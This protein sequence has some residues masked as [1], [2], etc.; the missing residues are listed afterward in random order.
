MGAHMGDDHFI[1]FVP[2]RAAPSAQSG[3]DDDVDDAGSQVRDMA[4]EHN[5]K[6]EPGQA[7]PKA[8][9]Q[10]AQ[11]NGA[12]AQTEVASPTI[13]PDQ[14]TQQTNCGA[15]QGDDPECTVSEP[16]GYARCDHRIEIR[17][18]AV[19]L[20]AIACGRA[21]QHAVMVHPGIIAAFV[22]DALT[23]SGYPQLARIRVHP[24][25]I[26]QLA[27]TRYDCVGDDSLAA[28]DVVVECDDLNL[29][30][31]LLERAALLV[32]SAEA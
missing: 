28:G 22:D 20:A 5:A 3:V 1:P 9:T 21:L 13:G 12:M 27:A 31:S 29:G 4:A 17:N 8:V 18:T 10:A 24:D 26:E 16:V 25:S 2:P 14:Q 11:A 19:R 23:A 30:A 32:A 6:V 15:R 7:D